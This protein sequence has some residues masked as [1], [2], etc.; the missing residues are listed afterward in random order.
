MSTK[1]FG[2]LV[3]KNTY[4]I[5]QRKN[6]NRA[7]PFTVKITLGSS[8]LNE[9]YWTC[10]LLVVL[11]PSTLFCSLPQPSHTEQLEKGGTVYQGHCQW[12]T[13]SKKKKP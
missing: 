2:R 11:L 5:C 12:D 3:L 10:F 9:S 4:Y 8:A 13:S 6:G 1:T 7:D